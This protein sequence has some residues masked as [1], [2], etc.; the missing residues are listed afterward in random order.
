MSHLQSVVEDASFVAMMWSCCVVSRGLKQVRNVMVGIMVRP[1][2]RSMSPKLPCWRLA[3]IVLRACKGF[4]DAGS[5][6]CVFVGRRSRG[7]CSSTSQKGQARIRLT[8]VVQSHRC[9]AP[10]TLL[11]CAYERIAANSAMAGTIS[12]SSERSGE[13]NQRAR[14]RTGTL[15]T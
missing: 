14:R 9:V 3:M 11:H 15:C 4:V 12:V 2:L 5:P 7:G 8:L 13:C 1:H 6:V 10:A